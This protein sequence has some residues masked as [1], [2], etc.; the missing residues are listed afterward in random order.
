MAVE[1]TGPGNCAECGTELNAEIVMN[2]DAGPLRFTVEGHLV[3]VPG[4]Y[5][6]TPCAGAIMVG[7]KESGVTL[8]AAVTF[9]ADDFMPKIIY[10]I[11]ICPDD[12]EMAFR[13]LQEASKTAEI[14]AMAWML[15]EME[16]AAKEAGVDPEDMVAMLVTEEERPAHPRDTAGLN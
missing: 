7:E 16:E 3:E 1:L 6:C 5:V 10:Y 13:R 11:S 15:K 12:F 14:L 4:L 9:L 8:Q 2:E